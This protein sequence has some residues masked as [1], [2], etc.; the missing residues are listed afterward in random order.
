MSGITYR[1]NTL[2]N[3]KEIVPWISGNPV[4]EILEKKKREKLEVIK[5]LLIREKEVAK[6]LPRE[7]RDL[8]KVPDINALLGDI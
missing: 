8:I 5:L 6:T 4:E 1:D 3:L 7:V 2:E